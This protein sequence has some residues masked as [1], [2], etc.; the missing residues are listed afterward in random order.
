MDAR[1]KQS[2]LAATVSLLLLGMSGALARAQSP[3][4]A[5]ADGKGPCSNA[6]L[7]GEYGFTITGQSLAGPTAGPVAGVAM[8][9]YDGQGK[10]TQVDHV[11]HNG[12]APAVQWRPGAGSYTLNGDCTG[13]MEI[14]FTDGS[15]SLHLSIVVVGRGREIRTVVGNPETAITSLGIKRDSPL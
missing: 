9:L 10:L 13:T 2:G 8:T 1:M 4:S 14:N 11:L 3:D 12:S 15:P 5:E 7:Q 6:T